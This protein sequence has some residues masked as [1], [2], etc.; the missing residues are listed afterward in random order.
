MTGTTSTS[1]FFVKIERPDRKYTMYFTEDD[2]YEQAVNSQTAWENEQELK[3]L[4][5]QFEALQAKFD[6]VM[7]FIDTLKNA[8]TDTQSAS[9]EVSK[10][11]IDAVIA[12]IEN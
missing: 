3:T 8:L 1:R 7:V 2:L 9:V 5:K 6:K 10:E 12:G 11:L 4:K